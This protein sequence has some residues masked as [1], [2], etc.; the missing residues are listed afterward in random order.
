MQVI[1]SLA[2]LSL[3]EAIFRFGFGDLP[4]ARNYE[5]LRCILRGT[6]AAGVPMKD[7]HVAKYVHLVIVGQKRVI[8]KLIAAELTATGIVRGSPPSDGAVSIHPD[9]WRSLDLDV[10]TSCAS[11][12]GLVLDDIRISP[13]TSSL[14]P[15]TPAGKKTVRAKAWIA[16]NRTELVPLSTNERARR[17][18]AAVGCCVSTAK[19]AIRDE[20]G[21]GGQLSGH[22]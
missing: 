13:A 17:V 18:A 4:E 1:E 3:G 2:G 20:R 15:D 8:A 12:P 9:R 19:N 5:A 21:P 7:Q 6:K 11:S 22:N 10:E 16:E 14:A